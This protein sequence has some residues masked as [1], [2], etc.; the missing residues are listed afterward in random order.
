MD[1]ETLQEN[2]HQ[3]WL[4]HPDRHPGIRWEEI[5]TRLSPE[6]LEA[7]D[8]MEQTG[9]EPDILLL[10]DSQL[11]LVD[12]APESPVGRR[13]LSYDNLALEK[14][15]KNKPAG[16]AVASATE[17]GVRLLTEELY[18]HLQ[19]VGEFDLKTSSWIETPDAIRTQ[20]GAL[21]CDRRYGHVFLYHN[22]ADSYYANRG[23]RTYLMLGTI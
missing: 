12:C 9:G 23:F 1:K 8:W 16:S 10:P 3:R 20:G 21:Y 17:H 5:V 22:G 13:S 6:M 2:L 7:L 15:K 11:L 18:R 4:D 19:T 14:R